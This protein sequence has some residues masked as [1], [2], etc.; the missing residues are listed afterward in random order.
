M[1]PLSRTKQIAVLKQL[2]RDCPRCV[3]NGSYGYTCGGLVGGVRYAVGLCPPTQ[4]ERH[5]TLG[6]KTLL[7]KA[8]KAGYD[9]TISRQ[10]LY[11]I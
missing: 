11:A 9:I 5:C 8:F 4:K 1:N 2:R 10:E 6:C 3:N 7:M